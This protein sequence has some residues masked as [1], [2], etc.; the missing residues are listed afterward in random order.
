MRVVVATILAYCSALNPSKSAMDSIDHLQHNIAAMI[1]R[2]PRNVDETDETY[3]GRRRAMARAHPHVL[4]NRWSRIWARQTISWHDHLCR[5]HT[6]QD[7]NNICNIVDTRWSWAAQLTTPCYYSWL[8]QIRSRESAAGESRLR[9]RVLS[10][11]KPRWDDAVRYA[12]QR[13]SMV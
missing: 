2:V 7:M 4:A 13:L 3:F 6:R 9:R 1:L 12:R 11:V 8:A 5:E 10:Q